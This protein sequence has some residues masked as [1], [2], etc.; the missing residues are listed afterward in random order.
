M[1]VTIKD[2]K[3]L[4]RDLLRQEWDNTNMVTNLANDDI[5]VGWWDADKAFPQVTVTSDEE[6]PLDGG[7]TGVTGIKGDG[8]GY[9]QIRNGTVLVD[10]WAGSQADYDN[11]G[12]E[13]VQLQAM[14][15]E[16]EQIVY[17][18]L[19]S[20]QGIDSVAIT[21]RTKL[22]DDDEDPTEHRCQFEL[23]YNWT[24]Q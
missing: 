22:V 21:A 18:N 7:E 10:C 9:V 24:K 5:H 13:Q 20:L 15:D 6:S 2:I 19:Q 12:E 8:S 16:V 17:Q 4:V 11:V 23:T 14:M 1:P 3:L